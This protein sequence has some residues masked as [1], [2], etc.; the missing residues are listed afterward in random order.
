[1]YMSVYLKFVSWFQCIVHV[2]LGDANKKSIQR[3]I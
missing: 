2:L 3:K 1:M